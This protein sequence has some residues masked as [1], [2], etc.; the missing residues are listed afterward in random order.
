MKAPNI[1]VL[2][3]AI[4][5]FSQQACSVHKQ[6]FSVLAPGE[7]VRGREVQGD[8]SGC[9]PAPDECLRTLRSFLAYCFDA[10]RDILADGVS[11]DR[12]LTP[13]LRNQIL[14][15]ERRVQERRKEFPTDRI[16]SVSNHDFIGFWDLPS[17]FRILGSRSYGDQATIDVEYSWV[18]GTNYDGDIERVAYGLVCDGKTWR[19]DDVFQLRG[20]YIPTGLCLSQR[21]R[22]CP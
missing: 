11:Q 13:A 8:S 22:E 10:K 19:V 5:V 4:L 16:D 7:T 6:A 18:T 20:P 14:D 21:L 12:W 15:N 9:D 2:A 17:T 3:V 1:T